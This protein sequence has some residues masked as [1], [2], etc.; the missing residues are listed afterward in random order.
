MWN[1]VLNQNLV[2]RFVGLVRQKCFSH[3]NTSMLDTL[4]A[5][6]RRGP[7]LPPLASGGVYL[8]VPLIVEGHSHEVPSLF[9]DVAACPDAI[10]LEELT[11]AGP[12]CI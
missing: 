7:A 4:I 1:E 2:S 5:V 10:V 9:L 12:L 8:V 3:A 6:N 11:S